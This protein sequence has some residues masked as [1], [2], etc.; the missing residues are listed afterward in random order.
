MRA[1]YHAYLTVL[2]IVYLTALYVS[3][4]LGV[5]W[6]GVSENELEKTWKETIVTNPEIYL[7][8]LRESRKDL[9]ED[10]RRSGLD[11]NRASPEHYLQTFPIEL[12]CFV[13]WFD[14]RNSTKLGTR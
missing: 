3:G 7:E 9:I 1:T 2:F 14:H 11:L 6:M 13:S 5:E 12:I 4:Q 10:N 8:G